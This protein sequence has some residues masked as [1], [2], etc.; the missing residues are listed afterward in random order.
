MSR[1][2]Y[3]L[4]DCPDGAGTGICAV[5]PGIAVTN[6]VLARY[7]GVFRL[8]EGQS[9][10]VTAILSRG[11]GAGVEVWG[12]GAGA[13][14]RERGSGAESRWGEGFPGTIGAP[15]RSPA[16]YSA[17][18]IRRAGSSSGCS[19][20]RS[21]RGLPGT[22]RRGRGGRVRMLGTHGRSGALY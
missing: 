21:M 9:G 14:E 2:L 11:A 4:P 7:T 18:E 1:I 22:W 15:G 16:V 6:R 17:E 12:R 20:A 5:K 13:E 10:Y 8:A 19:G 3:Y